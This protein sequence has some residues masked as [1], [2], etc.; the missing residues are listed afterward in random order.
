M[1]RRTLVVVVLSL[2]TAVGSIGC[3]DKKCVC[4]YIFDPLGEVSVAEE[5]HFELEM[6]EG[7]CQTED[8]KVRALPGP[9][10]CEYQS[11]SARLPTEPPE[12]PPPETDR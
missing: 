1:S 11:V 2:L 10:G 6:T 7:E 9:G 3:G 8:S 4:E 5:L 12:S